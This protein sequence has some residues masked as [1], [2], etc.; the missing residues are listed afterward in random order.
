MYS[1][2]NVQTVENLVNT[3]EKMHKKTTWNENYIYIYI[4]HALY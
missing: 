4:Y 3:L 2:Y 1:I